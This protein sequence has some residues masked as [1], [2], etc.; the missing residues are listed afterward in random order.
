MPE[1]RRAGVCSAA[2]S[3]PASFV[4]EGCVHSRLGDA[5]ESL[6]SSPSIGGV[7]CYPLTWGCSGW[8]LLVLME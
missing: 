3:P 4:N 2:P 1:G 8:D 6:W 7:C 5:L